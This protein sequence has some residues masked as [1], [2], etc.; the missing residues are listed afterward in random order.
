MKCSDL[1]VKPVAFDHRGVDVSLDGVGPL[2]KVVNFFG[3]PRGL[4]ESKINAE[5][6]IKTKRQKLILFLICAFCAYVWTEKL[7]TQE[8]IDD[9]KDTD[10]RE[11]RGVS[12]RGGRAPGEVAVV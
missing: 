3:R 11:R 8:H 6:F 10:P 5:A 7:R 9:R 2:A 12:Q 4:L 1:F